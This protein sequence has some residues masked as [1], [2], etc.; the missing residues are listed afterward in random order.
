MIVLLDAN[1]LGLVTKPSR[2][3]D[4]DSCKLWLDG[5]VTD[6]ARVL[7][8]E[9]ADYEVRRELLRRGGTVGLR[10][11]DVLAERVGYVHITTLV[12]RRAAELWAEARRRGRPTADSA[13]LDGDV[14]LAAQAL[15]AAEESGDRVVV[16]TSNVRHLGQFVDARPWQEIAAP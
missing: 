8:P 4:A 10:R 16:A 12:M 11:L 5:L 7:V 13:A 15:L 14:I 2:S 6:S 1:V 9:I 3:P